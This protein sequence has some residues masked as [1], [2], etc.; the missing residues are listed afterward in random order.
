MLGIEAQGEMRI[1]GDESAQLYRTEELDTLLGNE[2]ED[3]G[4]LGEQDDYDI[5]EPPTEKSKKNSQPE[6][7]KLTAFDPALA[8][9]SLSEEVREHSAWSIVENWYLWYNSTLFLTVKAQL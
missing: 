8:T 1:F 4:I 9:L 5:L 6:E 7:A 2:L 3:Q